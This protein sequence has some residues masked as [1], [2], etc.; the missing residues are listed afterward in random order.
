MS[1]PPNRR[2][3]LIDLFG[4]VR[5]EQVTP[6]EFHR[7]EQ[8]LTEDAEARELYIH[9]MTLHAS[10]EQVGATDIMAARLREIL[11]DEEVVRELQAMIAAEGRSAFVA[12]RSRSS[13]GRYLVAIVTAAAL[14]LVT[15]FLGQLTLRGP[16]EAAWSPEVAVVY[17]RV[18]SSGMNGRTQMV[19]GTVIRPG[20]S[21]ATGRNASV[22]LRY[23]DGSSVD[24]KAATKLTVLKGPRAKRLKLTTGTA[25]FDVSPQPASAPLIV[26]P[27]QYDQVEVVGTSFQVNRDQKGE[28]RVFVASGSVRFGA[29]GTVVPVKATQSSVAVGQQKPSDPQPFDQATL[30]RGLSCGLTA[31]YYD[32]ENL[33]GESV[34]RLDP[35]VDFDWGKTSPDPAIGADKFS[36]RWT[37]QVEAVHTEPY[38]FYVIADE[39][40]RLWI[41][42]NLVV[43]G[44]KNARGVKLPSEPTTLIAGRTYDLKLEYH[45]SKDKAGIQLLWSS[46]STPRASVPHS[47]LHPS[48]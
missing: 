11:R 27:G 14:I 44:W 4:A 7:L 10:L 25:Y 29:K 46:P 26:N 28:T 37:G 8:L 43:D 2:D 41:D 45:E 47:Q 24:L 48:H 13:S 39:G 35:N 1:L 34:T 22:R 18:E 32:S 36:A 42:G 9:F 17:G 16:S 33:T 12:K 38:T 19:P 3:E 6:T 20:Q 15:L 40:A 30:W 23:P 31:T 5:D 21:V